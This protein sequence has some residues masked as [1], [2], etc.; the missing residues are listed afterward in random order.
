LAGDAR[1]LL[2][3]DARAFLTCYA[4]ALLA[5]DAR[6]FLTCYARAFLA[7]DARAFLTCYARA[8]LAGDSAC[9]GGGRVR[10]STKPLVKDH[11]GRIPIFSSERDVSRRR[12]QLA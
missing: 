8:L 4:R 10:V 7:S 2:A 3:G 12:L 5:G 6:A 1:A 11:A 9:N